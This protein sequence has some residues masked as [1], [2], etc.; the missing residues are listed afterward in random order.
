MTLGTTARLGIRSRTRAPLSCLFGACAVVAA[1]GGP[2]Q[3]AANASFVADQPAPAAQ[4]TAADVNPALSRLPSRIR[5]ALEDNRWAD[6]ARLLAQEQRSAP[7]AGDILALQAVVAL[8]TQ[9]VGQAIAFAEAA[10]AALATDQPC[11]FSACDARGL[12]LLLANVLGRA[13]LPGRTIELLGPMADDGTGEVSLLRANASIALAQ[14]DEA[15]SA[16]QAARRNSGVLEDAAVAAILADR[17]NDPNTAALYAQALQSSPHLA[18][19][20]IHAGLHALASRDVG[21]ARQRLSHALTLLPTTDPTHH[22]LRAL[23]ESLA[24]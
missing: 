11:A 16:L 6:A 23:L 24:P 4:P 19:V 13:G 20:W 15:A 5:A 22:E 1:C 14:H 3:G 17:Q 7:T 21:L 8:Q 9:D 18:A 10:W 12:T 2:Q